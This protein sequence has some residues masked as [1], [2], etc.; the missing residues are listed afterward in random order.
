MNEFERLRLYSVVQRPP[1]VKFKDLEALVSS[2]IVRNQIHFDYRYDFLRVTGDTVLVPITVQVPNRQLTFQNKEGV[3]SAVL[4]LFGRISTLTGRIVQTFEDVIA[5]DFPDSLLQQSLSSSS[6]YQK[7][8]PLRPGLY[9]LD[10]VLKDEQSGNV[11]VVNARLAVPRYDGD[12]L[13]ASSLILADQMEAV[14]AKQV[15]L[16]QFVLGSTKV[17]PKLNGEF[18]TAEKMGVF[19]QIYNL[20]VDEKTHKT[21]ASVEYRI[22]KDQQ[23][24]IKLVE[25]SDQ[26]KQTGEQITI[27]HLIALNTLPPGRYKF[28]IQATDELTK[29]TVSRSAEF[30]V[31][32]AVENNT[33]AQKAP[34]R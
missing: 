25:N 16:G 2:R 28:E 7:A 33:A 29:Q 24:V 9:R 19:L 26:L 32:A 20:K 14:P 12:K 17:R 23:D 8:V 10:L 30:T 22:R 4:N 27:E 5:R 6:I 15:G 11:G 3:H 18:T 1:A 34:G 13:E 21:N 31:K